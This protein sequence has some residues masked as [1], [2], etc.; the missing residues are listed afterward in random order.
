MNEIVSSPGSYIEIAETNTALHLTNLVCYYD[1][2]NANG[3]MLPYGETEE[4]QQSALEKAQTLRMMPSASVTEKARTTLVRMN[5]R[6]T[7]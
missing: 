3:V 1:D 2:V 4:E 6:L 7:P 5:C